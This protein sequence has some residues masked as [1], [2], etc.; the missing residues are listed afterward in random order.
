LSVKP[1]TFIA[2]DPGKSG[3]IAVR[4]PDGKEIASAMPNTDSDLL[5]YIAGLASGCKCDDFELQA[6]VEKVGGFAGVGHP[7]SRMFSFGQGYG[8]LLG[9]LM[10]LSIPVQLIRPQQW[11]AKLQL[12]KASAHKNKSAWK[13]HLRDEARRRFPSLKPTLAT[14]D[15][16]LMLDACWQK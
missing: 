13:R 11:Q 2:I 4:Y 16:L 1:T 5:D 6:I 3:G 10:A 7:G 8:F 12:G 15:A 14:A 9:V